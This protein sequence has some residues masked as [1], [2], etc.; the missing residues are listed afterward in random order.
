MHE[1]DIGANLESCIK[2]RPPCFRLLL[3]VIQ[4]LDQVIELYRPGPSAEASGFDKIAYID[5]PVL[6]AMIVNADALKVATP[7]IGQ[8]FFSTIFH[9]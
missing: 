9:H 3:S 1:R 5:L 2:K 7:L 6:E 4:W 8:F